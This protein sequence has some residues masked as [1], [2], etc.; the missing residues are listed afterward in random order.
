MNL[1]RKAGRLRGYQ[2]RNAAADSALPD[3]ESSGDPFQTKSPTKSLS[4]MAR[5][6]GYLSRREHSAAEL[7]RKLSA[8]ADSEQEVSDVVSKLVAK[9]MLSDAR[10]AASVVHRRGAKFGAARVA[11]ELKAQGVAGADLEAARDKLKDT[12][13][14]RCQEVWLRKFGQAATSREEAAKQAR[15]LIQR[16][17]ATGVVMKVVNSR[18]E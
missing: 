1:P 11:Q 13:L 7:T 9:G 18:D 16:G 8:F 17:F 15:F 10:Y 2:P 14:A 12:E 3:Q 4:L 6:V 5:A